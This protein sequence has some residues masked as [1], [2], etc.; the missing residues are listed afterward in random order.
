MRNRTEDLPIVF[1]DDNVASDGV[2]GVRLPP[3]TARRLVDVAPPP[4]R[5]G[6]SVTTGPTAKAALAP[7]GVPFRYRPNAFFFLESWATLAVTAE[8][9]MRLSGESC[10]SDVPLSGAARAT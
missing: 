7:K 3:R 10:I 2:G 9:G 4:T 5:S 8:R 6:V 1:P